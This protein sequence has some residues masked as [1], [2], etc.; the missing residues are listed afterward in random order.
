MGLVTERIQSEKQDSSFELTYSGIG[1]SDGVVNREQVELYAADLLYNH[2]T[3]ESGY[4]NSQTYHDDARTALFEALTASGHLSRVELS[5][6]L[7]EIHQTMI[8]VLLNSYSPDLPAHE[9][10]RQ[11]QELCEELTRQEVERAIARGFL[12]ADTQV[13]TI[14]DDPTTAGMS[15]DLAVSLGYRPVNHKGMVR[16]TRLEQLSGGMFN[17][18]TEQV[19]RSNSHS[20]LSS[21]FLRDVG[22]EKRLTVHADAAV[23]GTQILHSMGEGVVGIMKRLD[24][25]MG[26]AIRYGEPIHDTQIRYEDL[27]TESAVREAQ[28]ECYIG[29]LADYMNK[30]DQRYNSGQIDK[31]VHSELLKTE[32]HRILQA[33][34]V[35]RPEYAFDCFGEDSIQTYQDAAN[36]AVSGHASGA[37]GVVKSNEHKEQTVTF[38]GMSISRKE[39][40]QKGINPDSLNSLIQLGL[41]KW[42]TRIGACRVPECLSPKPTEVG[43]CDVC[44]GSCEPL[45][46]KGWGIERII[47]HYKSL[48]KKTKK[49][50]KKTLDLW[51]IFSNKK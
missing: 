44:T 5:G 38:C 19:S 23:L 47:G 16:S 34:C 13:A 6:S 22:F 11:F 21:E 40:E 43:G 32:I 10:E 30:I 51:S 49:I 2:S 28:A 41:E 20:A 18:V 39:A 31:A 48:R 14:S 25:H 8:Q 33:I 42:P 4:K 1:S 24:A 15:V 29:T 50:G 27:R 35:M 45:F 46:N 3:I 7:D 36:L 9:R 12:P 37:G 17:R 26:E